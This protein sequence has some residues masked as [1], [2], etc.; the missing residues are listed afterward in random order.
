MSVLASVHGDLLVV[1]P[2]VPATCNKAGANYKSEVTHLEYF[3]RRAYDEWLAILDAIV[4][5]GG[6]ALYAFEAADDPF[7]GHEAL[8]VDGDG[9]VRAAGSTEVL[10][11]LAD[12]QTGRV[13]TANGPWVVADD[14]QVRAVMQHMLPHRVG[15]AS[16]YKDLLARVADASKRDLAIV[17]NPHRW[18][19]MADVAVVGEKV[20]LT[21][22]VPGH[23]D[24]GTT[25]K[26]PRSSKEGVAFAAEQAGVPES[27]RVYVELVY[28]HFHGD[29][30]HFGARAPDRPPVLVHYAGGLW[31]DGHDLVVGALGRERVV[32]ITLDDAVHHYAGNS[33]QVAR[34]VLVPDGVTAPFVA[35]IEQLGLATRRIPLTELFAKAG[36]G[37]GCATL[38]LPST[39]E[40]PRNAPF[41]YSASRDAVRARRERIPVRLTV[42]PDFF[43]G[44]RRG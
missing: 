43:A 36:G 7:L 41:R 38:Y 29:T 15:E 6:D 1:R 4:D 12:V 10:G 40:I 34:G 17:D 3:P 8:E 19:G 39:L 44:K 37:P 42:S 23:Y 27:A 33:R 14:K 16:Y 9:N 30:V 13:F 25:P 32:P 18:E 31:G 28:P 26:S 20:V 2:P 35:S 21:Y 24:H 22:A 5:F 11:N